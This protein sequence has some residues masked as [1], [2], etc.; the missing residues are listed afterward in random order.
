MQQEELFPEQLSGKTSQ[1]PSVAIREQTSGSSSMK[2]RNVGR[3]SLNGPSW[4]R[5][6]SES[7]NDDDASSSS[8]SSILLSLDGVDPKYFLS[9]RAATGILRR[10]KRRN[11]VLPA[12]LDRTLRAVAGDLGK[13][14][15]L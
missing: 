12:Q 3:W 5:D 14:E 8:L 10:A 2:W 4:M 6:G 9:P 1:A 13:E 11:K 15:N 7:P